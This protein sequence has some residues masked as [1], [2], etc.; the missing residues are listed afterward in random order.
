MVLSSREC[1]E[2]YLMGKIGKKNQHTYN[3]VAYFNH[4]SLF[5]GGGGGGGAQR[6][7]FTFPG[8]HLGGDFVPPLGNTAHYTYTPPPPPGIS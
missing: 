6:K 4:H 5:P 2:V 3:K 7:C 1:P 8:L